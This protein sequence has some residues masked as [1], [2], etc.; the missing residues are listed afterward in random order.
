MKKLA[1]LLS[2]LATLWSA[3]A[4]A[5]VVTYIFDDGG[6]GTTLLNSDPTSSGVSN[7]V[8]VLDP[9]LIGASTWSLDT[10]TV[11]GLQGFRPTPNRGIA[12]AGRNWLTGNTFNFT[13]TVR[14]GYALNLTGFSF[15]EQGSASVTGQGLGPTEWQL[16][17]NG[18]LV[19]QG[20]ASRGQ[21]AENAESGAISLGS[22]LQGTLSFEMRAFYSNLNEVGISDNATWRVDDFALEGAVT[23]VPLLGALPLM[24]SAIGG[25][26]ALR[27]RKFP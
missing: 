24:L 22:P 20:S 7:G 14:P 16:F 12:V 26:M 19:G 1:C 5:A 2:V 17:V 4:A 8:S 3:G 18:A 15:N 27:L 6:T 11:E 9:N 10:G 13:L 25:L 23:A 21:S